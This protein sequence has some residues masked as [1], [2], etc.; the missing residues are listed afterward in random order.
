MA[1]SAMVCSAMVRRLAL[2]SCALL[3]GLALFAGPAGAKVPPFEVRV[4]PEEVVIG[5]PVTV[6]VVI[7]DVDWWDA[8]AHGFPGIEHALTVRSVG[9]TYVDR[10]RVSDRVIMTLQP[11]RVSERVWRATFRP[12]RAGEIAIVAYENTN[13]KATGSFA[14]PPA[15][16]TVLAEARAEPPVVLASRTSPPETGATD[17]PTGWFLLA[18]VAVVATTAGTFAR[19]W[20]RAR[21][22]V[23]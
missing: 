3:V 1:G 7:D 16:V 20:R 9:T 21:A 22:R 4:A 2:L 10:P 11:R 14:P 19:R 15:I 6:D 5:D 13:L 12:R 8:D 17:S 18:A 23:T